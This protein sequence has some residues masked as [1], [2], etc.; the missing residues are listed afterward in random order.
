MQDENLHV[1]AGHVGKSA[2]STGALVFKRH[3]HRH[4]DVKLVMSALGDDPQCLPVLITLGA[5]LRQDVAQA[6]REVIATRAWH[7]DPRVRGAA[8]HWREEPR[9]DT[10]LE[11]GLEKR[12]NRGPKYEHLDA[13]LLTF[14]ETRAALHRVSAAQCPQHCR[15]EDGTFGEDRHV[16]DYRQALFGWYA[17]I[18]YAHVCLVRAA[19]WYAGVDPHDPR[20]PET[21]TACLAGIGRRRSNR[22]AQ[23]ADPAVQQ[24]LLEIVLMMHAWS[25]HTFEAI[26]VAF[27]KAEGQDV[28]HAWGGGFEPAGRNEAQAAAEALASVLSAPERQYVRDVVDS[29]ESDDEEDHDMDLAQDST[30]TCTSDR[31][32]AYG[33]DPKLRDECAKA[34]E[35]VYAEAIQ[36]WSE[37]I[38]RAATTARLAR[39]LLGPQADRVQAALAAARASV[40]RDTAE[41]AP[42]IWHDNAK[43]LSATR[44]AAGLG[45]DKAADFLGIKPAT[46]HRFE[47]GAGKLPGRPASLGYLQ[48]IALT[49]AQEGHSVPAGIPQAIA[50]PAI[51]L[52]TTL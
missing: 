14:P 5:A 33:A 23:E 40:P 44:E 38:D 3:L 6:L 30:L 25:P 20:R 22:G 10:F 37:D 13:A 24:A 8:A 31:H 9:F 27:Q 7:N 12:R 29:I 34:R 32:R 1:T 15:T 52:P 18:Q 46:L 19:R 35:R 45:L 50:Q 43:L 11:Q 41:T 49:C 48:L 17:A 51:S 16:D 42:H 2:V 36:P 39:F 28:S 26:D 47:Q 4:H 21:F